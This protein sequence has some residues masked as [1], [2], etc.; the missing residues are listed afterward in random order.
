MK[1]D[2]FAFL[3]QQLAAMLRSG[4]P[5][6]GA[7]R[8][9]CSGMKRGALRAQLEALERDLAAGTPLPE[10]L[11]RR[12]LPEFYKRM[13]ELGARGNDLPGILTVLADHYHR[14]HATWSRL[15][16]LMVYPFLVLVAAL[17]LSVLL[18]WLGSRMSLED[19]LPRGRDLVEFLG[20]GE[21][22]LPLEAIWVPPVVLSLLAVA[23]AVGLGSRTCRGWLRWH[24]PAFREASLAQVASSV[25]LLMR[26][27]TTLAD[28]LALAA[29]AESGTA[30]ARALAVWRQE[31]ECGRGKPAQ[32]PAL[33]PFPPL[34]LWLVAQGGEDAAAG[35]AKAAE[36]F[37]ARAGY[38]IE[39]ALYGALPVSVLLL[40]QMVLWQMMP[41]VQSAVRTMKL[42][43]DMSGG[44]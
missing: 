15:K 25:A 19:L 22:S 4:I 16:G 31:I 7:L 39:L 14:L 20:A 12:E 24:V 41:V 26:S 27:G 13:V 9:L 28:A 37:Q 1:T 2:E 23:A 17:G 36:I 21:P 8:Q 34:F 33:S 35:F 42:L 6:E 32:W 10:A 43:S 29:A 38:R 3:N 11:G 18:A 5:L 44:L 30:A 40:G